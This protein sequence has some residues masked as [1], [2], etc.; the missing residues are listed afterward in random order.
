[1]DVFLKREYPVS[2]ASRSF[3]Q[4]LDCN[5]ILNQ[6]IG[7]FGRDPEYLTDL[8]CSDA[9]ILIEAHEQF[10]RIGHFFP[11]PGNPAPFH[12]IPELLNPLKCRNPFVARLDNGDEKEDDP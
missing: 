2:P 10:F 7:G 12:V 8:L 11:E 9:W 6:L 1:M 5:Q 3:Y 4:Y